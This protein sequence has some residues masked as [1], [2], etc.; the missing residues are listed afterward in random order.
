MSIVSV[1]IMGGLGNQLFEIA[2]AYAYSIK[3]NG[4]LQIFKKTDNGNRPVYWDLFKNLN[5]YLVSSLPPNLIHWYEDS[6]TIY[7]HIGELTVDG[8]YLNGHLQSSKYFNNFKNEIKEL[9]KVDDSLIEEIKNKYKYLCDNSERVIVIHARRT[10]YVQF[11]HIHGPLE[12]IYYKDALNIMLTKV[13]DPVFL[14]TSDVNAFW[15]E[16]KEDIGP[17]YNCH[18]TILNDTDINTFILLQ[19]FNN[20]I[21]ANS[22][23]IWWVVWL[24]NAKNVIAPSKWFGPCGPPYEDIYEDNWIRI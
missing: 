6:P 18:Y 3:E 2:S 19:Q 24:S 21:M 12:S 7:K 23:F 22:T 1:N 15:E 8:K 20:F 9:F 11:K 13:E 17:V 10:D 4:I 16:I 5:K 14:L